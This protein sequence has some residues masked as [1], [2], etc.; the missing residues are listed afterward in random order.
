MANS[1]DSLLDKGIVLQCQS[2]KLSTGLACT[3]I[4]LIGLN[5]DHTFQIIMI[6][7]VYIDR[8]IDILIIVSRCRQTCVDIV[9]PL[10]F[11]DFVHTEI[12]I[13]TVIEFLYTM[14]PCLGYTDDL[15]IEGKFAGT[16][17]DD[18][19]TA[20]NIVNEWCKGEEQ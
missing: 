9:W 15:A 11:H 12:E 13:F 4:F 10:R 18:T 2:K 3:G 1:C 19:H 14:S 20:L 7:F 8:K 16:I 5:S 6:F 17:S